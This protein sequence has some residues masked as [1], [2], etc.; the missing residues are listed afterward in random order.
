LGPRQTGKT[1]LAHQIMNGLS[2]P[3]YYASADEPALKG[4]SW[5]EQQWE[6]ARTIIVSREKR[7]RSF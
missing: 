4:R 5:I 2:I 1:T 6:G 3:S 7:K